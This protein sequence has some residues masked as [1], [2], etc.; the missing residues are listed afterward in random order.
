MQYEGKKLRYEL[1]HYLHP[2]D[3]QSLRVR[4][5]TLLHR[6]RNSVS[7]EGYHI[8]SL[9]FDDLNN[10]ALYEKNYGIMKRKKYRIRIYNQSD[11][12]I[13]LERKSKFGDMICKESASL[14]REEY[15]QIMAGDVVFLLKRKEPLLHQ[16]YYG[17][18]VHGLSPKV[19]VD[20]T[21]EAYIYPL[22]DVRVT[23]D[24]GL[25]AVIN[26]QDI[27]NSHAVP[28][29][30]FREP[31]EI[32][33]VKYTGFLPSFIRELL[34]FHGS[35]RTAISKYVLCRHFMKEHQHL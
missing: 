21:R 33:E 35:L 3:H 28:M 27:F 20:Y 30:V 18:K 19:I 32:L 11:H 15:D 34:D 6:D 22:G 17:I 23:F 16:F 1:K 7:E 2:F 9:Y 5:N 13:K 24:K 26:T 25:A 29:Y 8:R 12:A 10:N 31:R 14:S 4:L